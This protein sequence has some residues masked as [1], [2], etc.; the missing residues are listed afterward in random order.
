MRYSARLK[1][2]K[3]FGNVDDVDIVGRT[4]HAVAEQYTKL[5]RESVELGGNMS[6]TKCLLARGTDRNRACI[7]SSV[8]IDGDE[9]E[10]VKEFVY[11]ASLVTAENNCSREVE[12]AEVVRT[13]NSTRLLRSGK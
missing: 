9:L 6:R 5:K 4:F 12:A 11:F 13:M 10:V 7:G 2:A 8:V 3:D 1:H